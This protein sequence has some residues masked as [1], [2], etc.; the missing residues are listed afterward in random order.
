MIIFRTRSLVIP[1]AL[2]CQ[3]RFT[4]KS[5]QL[6]PELTNAT[7]NLNSIDVVVLML[8]YR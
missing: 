3:E 4:I 8:E 6:K 7:Q 1:V 5:R 2:I